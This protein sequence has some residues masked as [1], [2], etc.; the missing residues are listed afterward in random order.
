MFQAP[1]LKTLVSC[2]SLGQFSS[3]TYLLAIH[4]TRAENSTSWTFDCLNA[5]QQNFDQ[6]GT[7]YA[8]TWS[9]VLQSVLRSRTRRGGLV[10]ACFRRRS[11]GGVVRSELWRRQLV[12]TWS[13]H[14]LKWW[15]GGVQ[16]HMEEKQN[17][18]LL[19]FIIVFLF[20]S[21]QQ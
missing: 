14:M 4:W 13:L 20:V 21:W 11:L 8:Q 15:V 12:E 2:N 5:T 7:L 3:S 1:A 10:A 19:N 6:S 16:Y 17:I 18:L 9:E